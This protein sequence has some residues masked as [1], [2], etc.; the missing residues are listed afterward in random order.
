[1]ELP[2]NDENTVTFNCKDVVFFLVKY[3]KCLIAFNSSLDILS[4]LQILVQFILLTMIF[5]KLNEVC[6]QTYAL[7]YE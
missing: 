4:G 6:L 5:F 3:L 1:M 7:K 2:I